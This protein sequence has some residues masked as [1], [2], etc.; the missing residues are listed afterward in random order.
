[1]ETA[2]LIGNNDVP[3]ADGATFERRDPLTGML[4]TRAAAATA[5]DANNAASAAATAFPSWAAVRPSE[6]RNLLLA[7]A[8]LLAAR[9][10]DFTDVMMGETGAAA[11]WVNFNVTL[12]ANMLREAASLV[13]QINGQVYTSEISGCL[14]MS[15]RQPVGVVLKAYSRFGGQAPI[16]EFTDLR[17]ITVET[18]PHQYPF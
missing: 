18:E 8:E 1:V 3:A 17:W 2:L 7:A 16:N 5:D 6:R 11:P 15:I 10:K 9:A 4:V 12:A 13:M 14:S